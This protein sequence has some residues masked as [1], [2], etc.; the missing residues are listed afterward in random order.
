MDDN[1]PDEENNFAPTHASCNRSKGAADLRVARRMAEFDRLHEAARQRG[2]RG[3]PDI[4]KLQKLHDAMDRAILGAYGWT[5]LRP[6]RDFFLDYEEEESEE[7]AGKPRKRKKP[8][9]Y[10]WPDEVRD[11]VLAR[12]LAL[13]RE[14]ARQEA[15]T[16][17][18]GDV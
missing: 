16:A 17:S 15:L 4:L 7:D 5:D 1:G 2:E 12:L 10:R 3:A 9:R 13:N 18:S 11:E 8:W 6:A 14:R